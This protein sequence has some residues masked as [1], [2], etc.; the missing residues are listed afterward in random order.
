MKRDLLRKV[1]WIGD[2]YVGGRIKAV[3]LRFAGLGAATMKDCPDYQEHEWASRG[4]LLVG[5]F[6]NPWAWMNDK[7]VHFT[8]Q[9]VAATISCLRLPK[10]IPIIATGGSMG[11]HAA[12]MYTI[13]RSEEHTSELQSHSFISYAVFCLKKKK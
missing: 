7:T 8:D 9:V 10:D 6:H 4:A 3:V 11:G 2:E 5:P 13:K 1:C 12:L